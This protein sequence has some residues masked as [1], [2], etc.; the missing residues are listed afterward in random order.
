MLEHAGY[1]TYFLGSPSPVVRGSLSMAQAFGAH[2]GARTVVSSAGMSSPTRFNAPSF[3]LPGFL[4]AASAQFHVCGRAIANVFSAHSSRHKPRIFLG[5]GEK[6]IAFE[7]LLLARPRPHANPS[8]VGARNSS[9]NFI[10]LAELLPENF[11]CPTSQYNP[12]HADY[13]HP[14]EK[15]VIEDVLTWVECFVCYVTI[16]TAFNPHRSRNLQPYMSLLLCTCRRFGGNAWLNYD[17]A[18]RLEAGY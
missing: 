8:K 11:E 18:F 14:Q 2:S 6:Y 17:K 13:T 10:D 5:C 4:R 12:N 3:V 7:Y 9:G 15:K 16:V 1:R